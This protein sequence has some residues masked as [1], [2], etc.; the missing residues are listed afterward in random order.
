VVSHASLRRGSGR[1]TASRR[2]TWR[3]RP[4]TGC[5]TQL[6][7]PL[8]LL[9]QHQ[10]TPNRW[11]GAHVVAAHLSSLDPSI[12]G[13]GS[14]A[15]LRCTST[16]APPSSERPQPRP[17][18][19]CA[20]VADARREPRHDERRASSSLCHL[21]LH[22]LD[23]IV[24]GT[25]PRTAACIIVVVVCQIGP[26]LADLGQPREATDLRPQVLGQPRERGVSKSIEE[27]EK[28]EDASKRGADGRELRSDGGAASA[29]YAGRS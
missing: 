18:R 21:L 16:A 1:P 26:D 10:Y 12:L 14:C 17:I 15:Q 2:Q 29:L 23:E 13:A 19:K 28:K 4:S 27:D 9:Q 5:M 25:R 6:L 3:R 7:D 22:V 20:P 24:Y 11:G 8:P